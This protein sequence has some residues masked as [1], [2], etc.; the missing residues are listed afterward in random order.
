ML[1]IC[2][3]STSVAA[4]TPRPSVASILEQ[5]QIHPLTPAT[6]AV[7]FTLPDLS[8]TQIALSQSQGRWVLLTFF[9]TW[10]GPCASEMPSLESL[11]QAK[12]TAGLEVIGVAME[13]EVSKVRSFIRAK[14]VTFGIRMDADG[15][16]G[17]MYRAA[18]IPV[19]YIISPTGKLVGIARGARNWSALV[20]MF[21]RLM[22]TEPPDPQA[23]A[24]YAQEQQPVALP[25][26][27]NPPTAEVSV[28]PGPHIVNRPFHLTVK[29]HW[30]GNFEN[31]LL[32]PPKQNFLRVSILTNTSATTSQPVRPRQCHLRPR[33]AR[34]T[35]CYL[36]PRPD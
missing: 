14:G 32:H 34:R 26:I 25:A 19:S 20:P 22:E 21:D 27:L 6:N 5:H 10:C 2:L 15:Q 4:Q 7:D 28:S 8:G 17:N 13:S 9:A 18:S 36:R 23:T 16:V 3:C 12:R 35:R 1:A 30:A 33:L 24:T 29:I 31:Y 11:N